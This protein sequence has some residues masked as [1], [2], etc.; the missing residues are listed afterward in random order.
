MADD[1]KK[2]VTKK[3]PVKPAAAPVKAAVKAPVAKKTA[4]AAPMAPAPAAPKTA[5]APTP[6]AA[7]KPKA[8][9]KPA[10]L[11]AAAPAAP[12]PA[13]P[14]T[15]PAVD[16][17]ARL[18][19]IQETAYYKAEARNFAPGFEAQDWAD[20]EREVDALLGGSA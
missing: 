14:A 15:K 7:P 16:A 4:P 11:K 12:K 6:A 20:A 10:V 5:P 17:Q 8:A 19:M 13:K 2:I 9:A 18:A 1:G 3:T